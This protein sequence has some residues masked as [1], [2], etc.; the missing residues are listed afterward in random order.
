MSAVTQIAESGIKN[1][2]GLFRENG[3]V[4]VDA[5]T[6]F[7]EA[8]RTELATAFGFSPDQLRPERLSSLA[9]ERIGQL[10]FALEVVA[11]IF[12]GD[13]VKTKFWIKTPN[14]NFGGASARDLILRGRYRKVLQFILAAHKERLG[15]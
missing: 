9:K 5:T 14:P 3:D 12:N 13:K 7:M 1:H 8:S 11:D 6:E 4:D 2:L 10:A 15:R